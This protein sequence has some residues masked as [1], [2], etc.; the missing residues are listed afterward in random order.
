MLAL[1]RLDSNHTRAPPPKR[2][3]SLPMLL[4]QQLPHPLVPLFIHEQPPHSQLHHLEELVR[5][6]EMCW[7]FERRGARVEEAV[8]GEGGGEG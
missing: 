6:L 2:K 3:R 1:L 8:V 7:D 4:N 5:R